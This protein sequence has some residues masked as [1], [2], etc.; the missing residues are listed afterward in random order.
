[1]ALLAP[2]TWRAV[3]DGWVEPWLEGS[4]GKCRLSGV[5]FVKYWCKVQVCV[6]L[7]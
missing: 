2:L 6:S 7:L 5:P 4:V 1:M 3:L